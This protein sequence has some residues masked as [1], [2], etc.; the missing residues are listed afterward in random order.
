MGNIPFCKKQDYENLKSSKK[1]GI[2]AAFFLA[3]P[4]QFEQE[5]I[6]DA[7]PES[8]DALQIDD[9]AQ[10]SMALQEDYIPSTSNF[11]GQG[12]LVLVQGHWQTEGLETQEYYGVKKAGHTTTATYTFLFVEKVVTLVPIKIKPVR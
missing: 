6:S 12:D 8:F 5:Q 9:S 1:R 10:P 4:P 3:P 7:I 2:P 11:Y